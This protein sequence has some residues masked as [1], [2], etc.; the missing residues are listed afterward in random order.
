MEEQYMKRA[1]EL[2]EQGM[3]KTAP[4]PMVG[5]VI[6]KDGRIVGEG[7]HKAYGESHAEVNAVKN[8]SESVEGATLYV[9][10]EPCSHYGKTPPCAEL[11]IQKRI[12]RVVIGTLDPNPLVEGKGIAMLVKAGVSVTVG[13]MEA[14]CKKLNEVFFYYIK[15]GKPYV[16]LKTAMSLDGKIA[17]VTGKSKWIT[18]EEAR[19]DVHRLRNRYA[20]IMT[21]VSTVIKDDPQL[22]CRLTGGKN[23]KRIILDSRL[24]IPLHSKVLQDQVNNQTILATTE[25]ADPEARRRLEDAGVKVL[26]LHEKDQ[27]VDLQDLMVRLGAMGIDSI[28][29]EGG[30]ELNAA[31]VEQGILQK[32]IA[33]TAPMILGGGSSR[34]PV[35]GM[36]VQSPDQAQSLTFESVEQI[37]KDMKMTAYFKDRREDSACLQEL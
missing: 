21:G 29:L 5:A 13:V 33:Y 6:L 27:R 35:G 4:N 25:Q 3:G 1:L 22:T 24:R 11:I 2:A 30:A 26:V 31:A 7:F 15:T 16:V 14:E 19:E 10:L 9:N 17:A 28:L 23:P 12:K 34:T 32:Y 36:G 18:G 37:G 8:A 20:G